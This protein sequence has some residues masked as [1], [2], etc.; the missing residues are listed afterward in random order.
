MIRYSAIVQGR[1][2]GVGFRY[3]IQLTACKLSLTG[4][5]KNLMNGNVE[6]EVQ[7]LENNVLSFVSEIKKGNGFAKV[8]DIDLNIVPVLDSEKKFSIKY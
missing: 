8:S 5:C 3:F 1:V 4:W 2:Q 6:I 7:G